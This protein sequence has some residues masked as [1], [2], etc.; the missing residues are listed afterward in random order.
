MKPEAR[1]E[2]RGSMTRTDSDLI[3]EVLR[4]KRDAFDALMLRHHSAVAN[5]LLSWGCARSEVDDLCQDTFVEALVSL[6]RFKAEGPFVAWLLGIA[7]HRLQKHRRR[8][9]WIAKAIAALGWRQQRGELKADAVSDVVKDPGC[10]FHDWIDALPGPLRAVLELR[11]T[12]HLT[13][14]QI[15]EVEGTTTG[16][17]KMR[18]TRARRELRRRLADSKGGDGR[19][20]CP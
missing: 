18:L 6:G 1:A 9:A 10:D 13:F 11:Y 2:A 16:A 19:G 8:A 17:V 7:R 15:A 12:Q 20:E 14:D 5:Y 4:G 3:E